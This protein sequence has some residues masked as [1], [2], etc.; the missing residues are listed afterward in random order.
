MA[1]MWSHDRGERDRLA[2][3]ER[4]RQALKVHASAAAAIQ[5]H[6]ERGEDVLMLVGRGCG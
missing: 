2:I 1:E 4:R 5:M 6:E 3:N